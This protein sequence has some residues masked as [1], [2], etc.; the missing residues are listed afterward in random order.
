M[1]L[2][3]TEPLEGDFWY[4]LDNQG[5]LTWK[6]RSP[7]RG[8]FYLSW[9]GQGKN[10]IGAGLIHILQ[11]KI[12]AVCVHGTPY[13]WLQP[14]E[15][16]SSVSQ[17]LLNM[18]VSGSDTMRQDYSLA[19]WGMRGTSPPPTRS[20][21][22]GQPAWT[23]IPFLSES[24]INLIAQGFRAHSEPEGQTPEASKGLLGRVAQTETSDPWLSLL[25]QL[26]E[27]LAPQNVVPVLIRLLEHDLNV[28]PAYRQASCFE[29]IQPSQVSDQTSSSPSK[30]S[31]L[32]VSAIYHLAPYLTD[33]KLNATLLLNSLR[34]RHPFDVA[35]GADFLVKCFGMVKLV[36]LLQAAITQEKDGQ[37]RGNGLDLLQELGYGFSVDLGGEMLTALTEL[38]EEEALSSFGQVV[39]AHL[40]FIQTYIQQ[41]TA[42]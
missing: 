6:P 13:Y 30:L 38:L 35:W 17:A 9:L 5:E 25:D 4:V 15:A 27:A 34:Q 22:T 23:E 18:Q 21:P 42:D 11:G 33:P 8:E 36:R 41:S 1:A 29:S 40:E 10:V 24:A 3:S 20:R 14:Y 31:R 7:L 32:V 37:V 16:M 12:A 2:P 28:T 39:R 19:G 26:D